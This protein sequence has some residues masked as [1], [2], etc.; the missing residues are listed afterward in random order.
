MPDMRDTLEMAFNN[1]R[2][3]I[4]GKLKNWSTPAK[5]NELRMGVMHKMQYPMVF[6]D[7]ISKAQ[8]GGMKYA[9]LVGTTLTTN[10][11]CEIVLRGRMTGPPLAMSCVLASFVFLR[12]ATCFEGV[13][14]PTARD[15]ET[16]V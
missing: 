12:C 3:Q 2:K 6:S 4:L 8:K 5:N 16:W 1:P 11:Q 14:P 10:P 9:A 7:A 13:C 15:P